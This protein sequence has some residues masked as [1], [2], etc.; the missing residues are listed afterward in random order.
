[1]D[2]K[3]SV[4]LKELLTYF[5]DEW[6]RNWLYENREQYISAYDCFEIVTCLP[7]D[8][9][10]KLEYIERIKPYL[11]DRQ[12]E[13]VNATVKA[14]KL[15]L[16]LLHEESPDI[17]FQVTE[18]GR[19]TENG[20]EFFD[21]NTGPFTS[22]QQ[23]VEY[24]ESGF[25]DGED[26]KTI[27]YED[28]WY[29]IERYRRVNNEYI[30]EADFIVTGNLNLISVYYP[31]ENDRSN[32]V[33]DIESQ[34]WYSSDMGRLNLPMPYKEGDILTV[35]CQP[36][37]RPH[38]A[39]V[40]YTHDI[41]YDCCSPGCIHY[42]EGG[43][44]MRREV[45]HIELR[46]IKHYYCGHEELSPLINVGLYEGQLPEDEALIGAISQYIKTH[47]NGAKEIDEMRGMGTPKY[48]EELWKLISK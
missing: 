37:H 43:F 21:D 20:I 9:N 1:M 34:K 38:H 33:L 26:Y 2:E 36:F 45:S 46:S 35:D 42:M 39:V 29:V 12:D 5:G 19:K 11:T 30:Y 7:I 32:C 40:I 24:H 17:L 44:M 25:D 4:I 22:Y 16:K 27:F 18:R 47:E 28:F 15:G 23:L 31:W 14:Y 13:R 41:I 3:L 6:Y 8:L 48:E 10:K